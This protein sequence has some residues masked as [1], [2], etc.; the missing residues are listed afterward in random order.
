MRKFP[1]YGFFGFIIIVI[2][3]VLLFL[4]VEIVGLYFTPLLWTGYIL[5]IDALQVRF[6][7]ISLITSRRKELLLMLPWSVVC[8]LVF[9][10]YNLRLHNW[11]YVA[12]PEN[13]I[14]RYIGYIWSFATIFP[15]ILE[16]AEF[17]KQ[18]FRYS[19]RNSSPVSKQVLISSMLL[20][21]CFLVIPLLLERS[22]AAKLFAIVWIGF[23]FLLDPINKLL[24]GNSIFQQW[25]EKNYSTTIALVFSGILCGI[26]WEFWNYWAAAKWVY[27]VPISIVGSKVFEMPL[28]GYL[29][30]IPFAI[31]VYVMQEFL[32]SLF[33]SLRR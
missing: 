19:S 6:Y 4:E 29:G 23:I 31:E 18:F 27:S 26:L 13:L 32:I 17:F 2:A 25:K 5:F 20:G 33:P 24:G 1:P 7:G 21:V 30:F 12:L 8:W 3:E 14:M 9:E 10:A 15:A 22:I 28:L 16:T 11:T